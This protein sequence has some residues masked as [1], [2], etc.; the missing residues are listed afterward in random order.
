MTLPPGPRLPRRLQVALWYLQ[1]R[2]M[3]EAMS[4]RYRPLFRVHGGYGELIFLND[5]QAIKAVFTGDPDELHAGEFNTANDRFL[6]FLVGRHS[7]LNVDG[8]DH[9]RQ[10]RLVL[11]PFHG[12]RLRAYRDIMME[13][14]ERSISR[15]PMHAPFELRPQMQAITLE[16]ILRSVCGIEEPERRDE[17]RRRADAF[18]AAATTPRVIAQLIFPR[19]R[20][21][22]APRAWERYLEARRHLDD[23]LSEEIERHRAAPGDDVL[24]LLLASRHEDG[25]APTEEEL[26]DQLM[27]LLAAGHETSANALAWTLDLLFHNRHVAERL[28][29]ELAVDGDEYLEAVVRECMRIRPTVPRVGRKVLRPLEVCGYEVPAGSYVTV[30]ILNVH[31][32]PRFFE[33]PERFEPERFLGDGGPDVYTFVPFGGGVRRCVGASFADVEIKTVLRTI[34]DRTRL[35]PA[36]DEPEPMVERNTVIVPKHGVSAVLEERRL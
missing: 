27:T 15:W 35:R 31:H 28:Q 26:R 2:R 10:R 4:R 13:A 33:R 24:S 17:F 29:A 9:L 34:L 3:E 21:R 7:L 11:P 6:F 32:D 16:V 8:G 14:A 1:R 36:R 19:L 5:P 30:S 23:L 20:G 12:E 18:L 22:L 25:T